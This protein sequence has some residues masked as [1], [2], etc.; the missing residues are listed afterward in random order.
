MTNP[1][2][3]LLLGSDLVFAR[4]VCDVLAAH[5]PPLTCDVLDPLTLRSRPQATAVVIDARKDRARGVETAERLR[6]MGFDS[7]IVLVAVPPA[8][9]A[10]ADSEAGASARAMGFVEVTPAE[11]AEQLVPGLAEQID[12]AK[13]PYAELVMRARRVVAAGQI[14]LRLQHA[15]NNPI[16]G[17]MAEAQLMQ[18]ETVTPE[19]AAALQRMVD[20]C[21]RLV[22]LTRT[23]DGIGDRKP[24][25]A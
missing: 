24:R 3:V 17:L 11:M 14:A 9:P 20:L 15:L 4:A 5:F 6:A 22:E 7:A 8:G 13:T 18:F 12:A 21:R 1:P 10:A 16:A 2:S 25:P 19:Q 23:L